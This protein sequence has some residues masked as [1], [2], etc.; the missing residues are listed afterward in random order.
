MPPSHPGAGAN[1]RPSATTDQ[2]I[3]SSNATASAFL[4][5]RQPT[6]MTSGGAAT[7][8][9]NPRPAFPRPPVTQA[10]QQQ[11]QQQQQHQHQP[12]VLP[13]PAPSDEPSPSL[14][15][16]LDS[17]NTNPVSLTDAHTM[18]STTAAAP[19]ALPVTDTRFVHEPSDGP[20]LQ[21][22]PGQVT[23][24]PTFVPD[25]RNRFGSQAFQLPSNE[26]R[27]GQDRHGRSLSSGGPTPARGPVPPLKKRRTDQQVPT[28]ASA[29]ANCSLLLSILNDHIQC[30]GGDD[31]LESSVERPRVMLLRDAC[32]RE[33][34][35]FIVLHQ[36]FAMWSLNPQD[37]YQ[38]LPQAQQIIDSAFVILETVL[39]KN[40]LLSRPFQMWFARFPVGADL[41][42]RGPIGGADVINRIA[43]FLGN[44]SREYASLTTASMRRGYPLLVDELLYRLH[45][46]SP[47]LQ[48]I[49]F[50]ACRRRMGVPD[51]H[52]GVHMDK[53]FRD[54]QSKHR[55]AFTGHQIVPPVIHPGEIEHRNA[56]LISFFK[57]IVRSA[58]PPLQ[59]AGLR[60]P[61]LSM[62]NT[63]QHTQQHQ[64]AFPSHSAANPYPPMFPSSAIPVPSLPLMMAPLNP[65][66]NHQGQITTG[67]MQRGPPRNTQPLITQ[68]QPLLNRTQ[69]YPVAAGSSVS[70]QQSQTNPRHYGLHQQQ[71]VDQRQ[72]QQALQQF[73]KQQYQRNLQA[74][75]SFPI[76][77]SHHATAQ[78]PTGATRALQAKD[79]LFPPKGYFITR[80]DW[81]YDPS[82]KKSIMMSLHQAHVRSPKRV[83]KDGETERL[84]QAMKTFSVAPAPLAPK[85]TMYEFRFQITEEQFALA[86]T[87]SKTNGVLLPVVEHSNG[88]LRWRIR[89]CVV[90]TSTTTPTEPQWATL[91]VSWPSTIFMTLN[92]HVL[93]IRRQTHNGKDLPTEVTDFVVCGT[94]TLKISI[95]D[96]QRGSTPNRFVAVEMLETLNHSTIVKSVWSEGLV[97]E[98]ETLATIRKRLEPT[99]DDDVCFEAPDL[100]IDLADPFTS[101]IFNVPTRGAECTHMEC[102][103]L[104]TWLNTRPSKP[105]TKCPHKLVKCTCPNTPEPSNPDKWRCPIC[106]KDARPYS[107]RIDS[108]LLKVRAQLEQE[109]KLGTKSMRVKAD[110]SWSVVLEEDEDGG[111]DGE[112]PTAPSA[113]ASASV[114]ANQPIPATGARREVEVIEI[115]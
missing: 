44:L 50:T 54:D 43:A 93:D 107:L 80:P 105:P 30:C 60:D 113:S 39:K 63:Q 49:L 26:L 81:P 23:A 73:N 75:G 57:D 4:G 18:G 47:V 38:R 101:T 62:Q 64:A 74:T 51:D 77:A 33:D 46:Y 111:S 9:L 106:S 59:Q 29:P 90:P 5:G 25:N 37:A 65:Y 48:F 21:E 42:G 36:L 32:N 68:G 76:Q 70:S 91:D 84:Y 13:S 40:Q 45:C 3:A 14:S 78:S 82:D 11:Q 89:C 85:N 20:E 52:L 112:V 22:V 28:L 7:K 67:T 41:F 94:N 10:V 17:P 55:S 87:K 103:D 102:F 6:W 19:I 92:H 86:A 88:A 53:A 66:G 95:P 71:L 12:A 24:G 96:V 100:S 27:D 61:L 58:M 16:V 109:G 98:E 79:P 97:P 104:E 35:F 31:A 56:V 1:S 99:T 72:Q 8:K 15:N 83:I 2:Q 34:E 108:F 110:G 114:R 115:D 69:Y